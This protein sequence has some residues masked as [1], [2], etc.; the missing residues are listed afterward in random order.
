MNNKTEYEN[1]IKNIDCVIYEKMDIDNLDISIDSIC[2]IVDFLQ[3]SLKDLRDFIIKHSFISIE[4]EIYFF[5]YIKPEV[6]GR[7]LYFTEV[8]SVEMRKPNGSNDAVKKIL[9]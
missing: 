9:Q 5:K 1:F 7:L 8:Y 6:L 4:E 2:E 3:K